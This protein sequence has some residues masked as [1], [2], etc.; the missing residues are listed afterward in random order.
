MDT[1]Q[2]TVL[3][4]QQVPNV[5]TLRDSKHRTVVYGPYSNLLCNTE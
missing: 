1:E 5:V 2:Q 4:F 3:Q